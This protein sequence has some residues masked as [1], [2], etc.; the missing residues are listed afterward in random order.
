MS[1]TI[2]P[3]LGQRFILNHVGWDFYSRCLAEIGDRRVRLTYDRGGLEMMSPSSEHERDRE[4]IG[5]LIGAFTEE[6]NIPIVSVGSTTWRRKR[7]KRGL[8]ADQCYYIENEPLVRGKKRINLAVDPPPD[9]AVEIEITRS[10]FDRMSIYAAIGI[11]EVW[12]FD[13]QTLKVYRLT[14]DREYLEQERSTSLPQLRP[15]TIADFLERAEQ[16]DET[17]W[18]R[19][20]RKWV[21]ENGQR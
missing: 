2:K 3:D 16:M 20:F 7:I 18:I 8:E 15:A 13:G 5:R 19:L 21:Q 11:P 9:L 17:S 1:T 12:R 10:A 14:P 4:L 6:L